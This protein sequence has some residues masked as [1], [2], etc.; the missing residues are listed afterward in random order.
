M[1]NKNQVVVVADDTNIWVNNAG[2]DYKKDAMGVLQKGV[3]N[4]GQAKVQ[5]LL[6]MIWTVALD[7]V[8]QTV[9][10]D[11]VRMHSPS[12]VL[13]KANAATILSRM[14]RWGIYTSADS[15]SADAFGGQEVYTCFSQVPLK[16]VI[17][18]T[19]ALPTNHLVQAISVQDWRRKAAAGDFNAATTLHVMFT[20]MHHAACLAKK[21]GL[22]SVPNLCSNM[23]RLTRAM[24]SSKFQD[25]FEKALTGIAER[26]DRR[27]VPELPSSVK[28][29][30]ENNRA[31]VKMALSGLP[32]EAQEIILAVFNDPWRFDPNTWREGC[33]VHWCTAGCCRSAD[34]AK[35]KS[36]EA[37]RRLCQEYPAIPLLY[38]WK[39]WEPALNWAIRGTFCNGVLQYALSMCS[40]ES[41]VAKFADLD[42]DSPDLSFALKQEVRL[43]KSVAFLTSDSIWQ[44]LG[45]SFLVSNPLADFMDHVSFIETCRSRVNLK[46]CGLKL[47]TSTS[48][49][50][51]ESVRIVETLAEYSTILQAVPDADLLDMFG[52]D[53]GTV[54]PH[55]FCTMCDTWRR[56]SLPSQR[57]WVQLLGIFFT[58]VEDA[59]NTLQGLAIAD[60][61]CCNG[62]D[63]TRVA[64]A[65]TNQGTD[66]AMVEEL[67]KLFGEALY[68]LPASSVNVEKLHANT[69]ILKAC[70]MDKA[71]KPLR[72]KRKVTGYCLFVQESMKGCGLRIGSADYKDKVRDATRQWRALPAG[73]KSL[74][75]QRASRQQIERQ[76]LTKSQRKRLLQARLDK[77]L[78]VA[79]DHSVWNC[80]L[81]LGNLTAALRPELVDETVDFNSAAEKLREFF[82]YDNVIQQNPLESPKLFRS[83]Q[84]RHPGLCD[85]HS[86]ASFVVEMVEHFQQ[87]L[88]NRKTNL[89]ALCCFHFSIGAGASSS[90]S[91]PAFFRTWYMLGCVSKKPLCHVLAPMDPFPVVEKGL[92]FQVCAR[93]G[94]LKLCTSYSILVASVDEAIG[95]GAN[96]EDLAF[97]I[98]IHPF[99]MES[100]L[101][102]P[103]LAIYKQSSAEFWIG[104]DCDPPSSARQTKSKD[105]VALPFGLEISR[106]PKP[107]KRAAPEKDVDFDQPGPKKPRETRQK[108]GDH[109][110]HDDIE[111][112][113]GANMETGQET[114]GGANDDDDGTVL[115]SSQMEQL[116]L[117]M[118]AAQ[119][120]TEDDAILRGE[121]ATLER[122][123]QRLGAQATFFHK[124]PGIISL[125][126]AQ[127][128]MTCLFCANRISKGTLR[129]EYA[130]HKNKPQRSIHTECARQISPGS[131]EL[132]S[133]LQW[134]EQEWANGKAT[135]L[136]RA[137]IKEAL[138][139]LRPVETSV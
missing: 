34:E 128:T 33:F 87:H 19:D 14:R 51:V 26:M 7:R 102:H 63:C 66:L 36:R 109:T 24:K 40:D 9:G 111:S 93:T 129:F 35:V 64:L 132:K 104:K 103:N 114:D 45:V 97:N 59:S 120:A 124:A 91:K 80:G 108:K 3:S 86:A 113:A 92:A 48:D 32:P 78:A 54:F 74:F 100:F 79:A 50:T 81:A 101:Q 96:Y 43:T 28:T 37:L 94:C 84:E 57:G 117:V 75:E 11:L 88:E 23:V 16:M 127:R 22:L 44:D 110:K 85:R 107:K 134:L 25:N 58:S 98:S 8:D 65:V 38:R 89:P 99:Q 77:S 69:Q 5:A 21:P 133:S 46:E 83:C 27:V 2:V 139:A 115:S 112:P 47:P 70:G 95:L 125:K 138:S 29:W 136:E 106:K 105:T 1:Q 116:K 60:C 118:R 71:M 126:E 10:V 119:G 41:S 12:Q 62:D 130:F 42:P 17:T 49:A 123:R 20:C 67:M 121:A 53:F 15:G 135:S 131:E 68:H 30:W 4:K 122:K 52:L 31:L 39:H 56:L 72:R 6:G 90:S 13:P 61:P 137:A 55:V 18:C 76:A 73:E 82:D